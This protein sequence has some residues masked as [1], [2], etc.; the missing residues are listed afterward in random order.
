MRGARADGMHSDED[1]PRICGANVCAAPASSAASTMQP[2]RMRRSDVGAY[3]SR[4]P[5]ALHRRTPRCGCIR[6]RL[7][8][9]TATN[10]TLRAAVKLLTQMRLQRSRRTALDLYNVALYVDLYNGCNVQREQDVPLAEPPALRRH[11]DPL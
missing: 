6:R 9:A 3:G 10:G 8:N 1:A 5:A 7:R 4:V 11:Y 2:L